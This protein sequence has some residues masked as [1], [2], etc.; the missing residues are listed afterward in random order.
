MLMT[1]IKKKKKDRGMKRDGPKG[2]VWGILQPATGETW[3]REA[4]PTGKARKA[5]L[6]L[7]ASAAA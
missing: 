3:P 6:G 4:W 5:Q 1:I 2:L 7:S